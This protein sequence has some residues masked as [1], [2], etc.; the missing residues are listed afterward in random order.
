M[1]LLFVPLALVFTLNVFSQQVKYSYKP[2]T[3]FKFIESKYYKGLEKDFDKDGIMDL[4]T[5]LEPTPDIDSI[6]NRRLAIYLSNNFNIEKSYQWFNVDEGGRYNW[7]FKVTNEIIDLQWNDAGSPRNGA[8]SY[9]IKLK[10]DVL[11]KK[12]KPINYTAT[13]FDM[14]VENRGIKLITDKL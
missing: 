11:T 10:Y 3:G 1:K 8:G 6:S 9:E 2:P 13:Y 4:I 14:P 12:I 7:K 5:I